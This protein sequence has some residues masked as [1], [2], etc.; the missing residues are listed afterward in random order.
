MCNINRSLSGLCKLDEHKF[1]ELD[2][3]ELKQLKQATN[4]PDCLEESKPTTI[5]L[6]T[7]SSHK[8]MVFFRN[9]NME[10]IGINRCI[11]FNKQVGV[12]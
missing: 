9:I 1:N 2:D 8:Q 6:F 3:M 12:D 11:L 7:A 10:I 5:M 4:R